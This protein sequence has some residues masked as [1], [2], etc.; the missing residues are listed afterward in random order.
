MFVAVYQGVNQT[1]PINDFYTLYDNKTATSFPFNLNVNANG[2]VLVGVAT[3]GS[4]L[5]SMTGYT[6]HWGD[7]AKYNGYGTDGFSKAITVTGVE[8]A[9]VTT[10][11]TDRV[12][13]V[14]I[15]INH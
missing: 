3:N 10:A 13:I 5:P 4:A 6:H 9:T 7:N 2:T 15:A 1:T 8:S 14:A 12:A 11:A